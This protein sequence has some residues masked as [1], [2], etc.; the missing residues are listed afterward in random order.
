[1]NVLEKGEL[2]KEDSELI[3]DLIK[4][5]FVHVTGLGVVVQEEAK[6]LISAQ[7]GDFIPGQ[8]AGISDDYGIVSVFTKNGFCFAGRTFEGLSEKTMKSLTI[9]DAKS[10]LAPKENLKFR[11]TADRLND[12]LSEKFGDPFLGVKM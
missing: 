1:M 10:I 3:E 5:N 9:K 7:G 6:R 8:K 4:N 2:W 12:P 11:E